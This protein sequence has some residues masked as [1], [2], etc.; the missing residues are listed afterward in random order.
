MAFKLKKPKRKYHK[1]KGL[2]LKLKKQTVYTVAAIWFWLFAGAICLSFFG[3]GSMLSALRE[4]L[5]AHFGWIMYVLP[6]FLVSASTLFFK[7]KSELGNQNV[8]LGLGIIIVGLM[9]LTRAGDIGDTLW[10][11]TSDAIA[12]EGATLLFLGVVLIGCIVLFNTSLDRFINFLLMG[13]QTILEWIA[14][15]GNKQQKAPLIIGGAQKE[16]LKIRETDEEKLLHKKPMTPPPVP[17]KPGPVV[18]EP[19][20]AGSLTMNSMNNSQDMKLWEYPEVGILSDG[21]GEKADRGD[22]RKNADVIEKTLDSFGVQADVVEVNP[23][24][25][26]TQYAIK[27]SLGTKVSKITSLASDMALALAAPTG[28]VRIEA[29]IPGRDLVGIEIPNRG[30]EFV[31]LK[32]MLLSDPMKKA[33]SKLAVAMGLDVSGNPL[34]GDIAKMP[35]VLVAGTTGSGKSVLLNAWI[36]SLLYRTTPAEVRLILVDPKRVELV[37]YN[38]VPHLLTPVIVEVDKILSALR[39][40]TQEMERRYKQFAEVGVRNLDGFNELSGFQALPYIVIIIDELADL[41]GYAPVEVEDTICRIAQMARATGIHLVVATQRPSVDVITGLIKANIPARIAFNVSSMIDS[42]VIIDMPGAEKLLGRG[43]MLY[44]PPDQAKPMR[45]QGTFVSDKEV[46]KV[47]EFF[48]NTQAEVHYTEEVL[49]QPATAMK[50]GGGAAGG[51]DGKDPLFEDALRLVCQYDKASAS[52]LQRRLSVGYARAARI[53]DQLEMAGIIGA[54]EGSKPRDVLIK[55][56]DE[57]LASQQQ[58]QTQ[59]S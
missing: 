27:L 56:P 2:G 10:L 34:I 22:V 46:T 58:A 25:A 7:V 51:G 31:T 6:I 17:A 38:G 33:K 23:G 21:P 9:A 59:E 26:V 47:V 42:R 15:L 44:V 1:R 28:Q 43:D 5:T 29:P 36:C 39:W 4:S 12:P 11:L 20:G 54:G 49:S 16:P 24:P 8:P 57:Y 53:L 55:N 13:V 40:A 3:E 48:K 32:R 35:H 52:L 41:M 37:G 19:Q 30:L 50:K 14:S 18:K 45:I